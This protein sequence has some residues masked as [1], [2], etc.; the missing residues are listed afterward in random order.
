MPSA[1]PGF[2]ISLTMSPTAIRYASWLLMII[3]ALGVCWCAP[4]AA[5]LAAKLKAV[6]EIVKLLK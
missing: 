1:D 2:S 4:D 6:V 5:V 3:V